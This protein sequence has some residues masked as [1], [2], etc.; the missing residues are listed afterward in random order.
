MPEINY[1]DYNLIKSPYE[2]GL[3]IKNEKDKI[4]FFG[5]L[6]KRSYE[7]L[8]DNPILTL[9]EVFKGFIHFS[10]LNPFFVFYD[11]EYYK[12]YSSSIIGDFVYSK[13]HK[14][15]IPIRVIYT[16]V[17]FLIC[18]IGLIQCLKKS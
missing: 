7:I 10:V 2:I 9:K 6:N 4:K 12:N 14:K 17:I 11:Y 5:Y 16:S 15:L 1:Q 13:E 3:E 8:L 18:F